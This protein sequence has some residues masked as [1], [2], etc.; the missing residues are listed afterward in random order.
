MR[1]NVAKQVLGSGQQPRSV[2]PLCDNYWNLFKIWS[3]TGQSNRS[4]LVKVERWRQL[5][6]QQPAIATQTIAVSMHALAVLTKKDS[7]SI[8]NNWAYMS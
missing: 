3:T 7:C 1:L 2:K 6:T 4:K 8:N 5:G